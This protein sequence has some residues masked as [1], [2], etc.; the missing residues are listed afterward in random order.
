MGLMP[1]GLRRRQMLA[2]TLAL[3][4]APALPAPAWAQQHVTRAVQAFLQLEEA[5]LRA[6]REA[7][8]A[9]LD[10]LLGAEFELLVQQ[11]PSS[12][13]PRETW[14]QRMRQPGATDYQPA[15]MAVREL[16]AVAIVSFVLRPQGREGR[17]GRPPIAVVDV[18]ERDGSRWVLTSRH[19]SALAGPRRL[20]PGEAPGEGLRKQI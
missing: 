3:A 8:T 11:A 1:C 19:A 18:W 12:S 6:L 16:G 15:D 4:L 13:T 14:L 20:L 17:A 10:A 5:L 2:R 9:Q 7:D